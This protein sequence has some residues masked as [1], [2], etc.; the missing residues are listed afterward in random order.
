LANADLRLIDAARI[1]M[2]VVVPMHSAA[3]FQSQIGIRKS[4][5]E[6]TDSTNKFREI[7]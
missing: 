2:I 5:I 6:T 3:I 4:K 7:E 1:N